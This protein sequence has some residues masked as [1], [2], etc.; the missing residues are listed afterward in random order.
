MVLSSLKDIRRKENILTLCLFVRRIFRRIAETIS[1]YADF[2]KDIIHIFNNTFINPCLVIAQAQS[3]H[4]S[5]VS[6]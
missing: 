6:V 5:V 2:F 4:I 1:V 3:M